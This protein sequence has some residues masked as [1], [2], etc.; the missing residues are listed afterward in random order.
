MTKENTPTPKQKQ[1]TGCPRY[2]KSSKRLQAEIY[3]K[4]KKEVWLITKKDIS[5]TKIKKLTV[6]A[7][8]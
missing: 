2:S 1:L 6:Q 3:K 5:N 4:K 7:T 8:D